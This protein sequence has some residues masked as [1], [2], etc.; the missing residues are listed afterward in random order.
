MP[1]NDD[2]VAKDAVDFAKL[3]MQ[4][5][6]EQLAPQMAP[7][8]ASV[9][10]VEAATDRLVSISLGA[11]VFSRL[12]LD[13]LRED[14]RKWVEDNVGMVVDSFKRLIAEQRAGRT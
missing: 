11:A 13:Q 8:V 3:L 7:A 9:D 14:Q 10:R 12:T 1:Y 5:A 2:R 4:V 6:S